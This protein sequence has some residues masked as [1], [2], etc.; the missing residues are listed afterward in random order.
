MAN[1]FNI[2]LLI[3]R[4]DEISAAIQNPEVK[5]ED[6]AKLLEEAKEITDKVRGS[7]EAIRRG[8]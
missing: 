8:V 5:L 3:K 7:I 6:A 2:E 4:L 1:D